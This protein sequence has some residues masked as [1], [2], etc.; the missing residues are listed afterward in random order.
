[1]TK[2]NQ[3]NETVLQVLKIFAEVFKI[4]SWQAKKALI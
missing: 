2:A 4:K 3:T 1:M